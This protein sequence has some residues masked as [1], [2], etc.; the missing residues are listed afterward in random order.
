MLYIKN[1]ITLYVCILWLICDSVSIIPSVCQS[2]TVGHIPELDGK[3][4]YEI[5][6][7]IKLHALQKE[8]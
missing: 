4:V 2:A 8:T 6:R 5:V 1:N 7:P 3:K